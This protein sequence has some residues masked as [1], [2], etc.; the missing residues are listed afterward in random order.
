MTGDAFEEMARAIVEDTHRHECDEWKR[1]GQ[2]ENDCRCA[3]GAEL[4][5]GP[6]YSRDGAWAW[7]NADG[8][9]D[10]FP[11]VRDSEAREG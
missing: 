9:F 3:C 6:T 5:P 1:T 11:D 7:Q 10:R 2:C 8:S 4:V